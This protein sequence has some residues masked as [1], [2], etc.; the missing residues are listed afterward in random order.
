MV[1]RYAHQSGAH[2]DMAMDQ[3]EGRI[4][5]GNDGKITNLNAKIR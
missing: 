1:T 5:T 2:I 3:L 4:G